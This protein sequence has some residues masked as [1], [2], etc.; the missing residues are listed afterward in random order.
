MNRLHW[1]L[2]TFPDGLLQEI[3]ITSCG[4]LPWD[5]SADSSVE[6][7]GHRD[8]REP[9]PGTKADGTVVGWGH[10]SSGQKVLPSSFEAASETWLRFP[11]AVITAWSLSRW[12]GPPAHVIPWDA[13]H[14]EGSAECDRDRRQEKS[15]RSLGRRWPASLGDTEGLGNG[16]WTWLPLVAQARVPEVHI[17]PRCEASSHVQASFCKEQEQR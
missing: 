6:H 3:R 7:R 1:E 15:Q 5:T 2:A 14:S 11:A 17:T 16:T 8:G 12:N 9:Q 13:E 10:N 4:R